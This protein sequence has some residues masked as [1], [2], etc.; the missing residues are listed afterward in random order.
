MKYLGLFFLLL[1]ISSCNETSKKNLTVQE[2]VDKSIEVAGGKLYERS[3]ISFKFRDKNYISESKDNTLKRIFNS[4]SLRYIDIKTNDSFQRYVDD[5]LVEISDSL[6]IVYGNSVHSVFYFAQLPYRLNDPAV[7]KELLSEVKIKGKDYYV[8]Q[9]TFDQENGGD[10]F[11]DTYLYWM[12]KETFMPDYLAYDFHTDGGGVRFREAYNERYV[13]G[14]RFV[15]YKNYKPEDSK[16]PVLQTANL[17]ESN[18]LELL[19]DIKLENVK[20]TLD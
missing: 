20:V 7:N 3:T 1:L 2:I 4:D 14:I 18:Q 8:I 13:N 12:N 9:V 19:S 17:F 11:D 6:A 15:D 5:V 10:D 16:T